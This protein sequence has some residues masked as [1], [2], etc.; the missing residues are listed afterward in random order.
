[1]RVILDGPLSIAP[2]GDD[3]DR[4][5]FAQCGTQLVGIVSAVGDQALHADGFA[6]EQVGALDIRCV[7]RG[8]GKAERSS[9]TIDECVDLRRP[10]TARDANGLGSSPPFAPPEHRCALT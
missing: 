6:D 7:A 9:E 1:V 4:A 10:T 5:L 3:G 8:Q 2:A